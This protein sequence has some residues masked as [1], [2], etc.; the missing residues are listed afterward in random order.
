MANGRTV[1]TPGLVEITKLHGYGLSA[2]PFRYVGLGIG[3]TTP[4][5]S[6]TALESEIGT[7]GDLRKEATITATIADTG[8]TDGTTVMYTAVWNP[9]EIVLTGGDPI[10]ITEMGLFNA[11]EDGVMYY[12][13][14][15][16]ALTFDETTGVTIKIKCRFSR[17]A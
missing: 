5:N 7:D 14:V 2:A 12:H 11:D 17:T 16:G 3:T 6:D 15:R 4:A 1:T 9:G 13:E 8:D 10:T